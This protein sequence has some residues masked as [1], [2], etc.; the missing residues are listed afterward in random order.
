MLRRVDQVTTTSSYYVLQDLWVA[1]QMVGVLRHTLG[2][3]WVGLQ[4]FINTFDEQYSM[5]L[6]PATVLQTAKN[7]PR[8]DVWE[9]KG[10]EPQIRGK[11]RDS[12]HGE[13]A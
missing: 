4:K 8:F 5:R 10:K 11:A 13:E 2:G 9:P 12:H 1:K 6:D 3:K 7:N